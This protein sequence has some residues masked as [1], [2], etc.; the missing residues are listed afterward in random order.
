MKQIK[1]LVF[2]AALMLSFGTLHAQFGKRLGKT[3]EDAAK[4]TVERKAGQKTEDA[5]GKAI[6]KATDPN[7]YKNK[8]KEKKEDKKSKKKPDK[9]QSD[10]DDDSDDAVDEETAVDEDNAPKD[11]AKGVKAA[12]MAYAKSDF[13]AG[14]EIIFEDLLTGEQM[15]EFP[16]QW[17]LVTGNAEISK[18]NGENVIV[19]LPRDT[20]IRP[21][22]KDLKNY[23]P[24]TYTIE[25]D[26]YIFPYK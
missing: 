5:V 26:I 20:K 18:A 11:D 3:I 24:E 15:G 6:D 2:A 10:G 1:Y 4:R 25:Y 19:L 21:F 12:E 16:S 8:E 13:V 7:S 14:D 22:M 23:L 17:D 9:K